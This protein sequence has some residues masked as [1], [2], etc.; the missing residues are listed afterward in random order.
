MMFSRPTS[1]TRRPLL[2]GIVAVLLFAAA[3]TASTGDRLPEFRKCVEICTDNNCETETPTPIPLHRRL[4]FWTCPA[5]CDYTCQHIITSRR[6]R[7][8]PPK[9][10]EQFHGKWPFYR[11]WGMQEPASV[12]FSLGNFWAHHTGRRKVQQSIPSS[13]PLRPWYELFACF[14]MASWVFSTIFHTRD[15]TA[16]EQLDYFAAGASV[17]YGLYYTPVRVFR[18]DRPTPRRKTVLRVWGVL[19]CLLYLAHVA[20]L[21]GVRWDYTYNM[22]ANVVAGVI[23]NILWLWFSYDKYRRTRQPWAIWPG[24]AV[25]C[26]MTVMSLELFDFPPLWGILDAHSLWHLGTIA[27]TVLWY[28]FLIKD[29]RDD[30]AGNERFKQ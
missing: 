22:A 21:K 8:M 11:L 20:Y 6:V 18:L 10:I 2:L 23:Q 4:L 28:N 13:Y 29:A 16:T 25:A 9:S 7:A 12:A 24:I 5:E 3:A 15:S 14:G 19:C 30:L 1:R 17:L 26:V 27:P